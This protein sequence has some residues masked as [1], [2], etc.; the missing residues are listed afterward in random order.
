MKFTIKRGGDWI[1]V[2]I[3]GEE[4]FSGH[5]LPTHEV[6]EMLRKIPGVEV[7][8]PT[9]DFCCICTEWVDGLKGERCDEC[10]QKYG[11]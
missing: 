5:S 1:E 8:Y 7:D 11:E 3:D 10:V 2:C 4:Q 9:G 6:V